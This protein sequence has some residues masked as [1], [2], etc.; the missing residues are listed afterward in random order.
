MKKLLYTFLLITTSC[1]A[2]SKFTPIATIPAEADFFTSDNQGNVYI[3]TG[4]ELTKYNKTGRLLYKY[5]DKKL[6]N[7]S[8]VDA[9]NMLRLLVFYKDFLQIVFLDNTLSVNGEA[10]S[11]DKI[12]GQQA[13]LVC[14]SHNSGIW[15]YDQQNFE[16]IRLDQNFEK[17][18]QTGNLNLLL[19]TSLQP[20]Y[21]LEY[22]NKVYLNN[23]SSGILIFDIYGTYYKTIPAKNVKKFQPITDW[24]Y[25]ISD[26]K[27]KAYNTKTTEEKQFEMPLQDFK[28]FR[29]EMGILMLQTEKSIVLYSSE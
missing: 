3:V 17:K 19:N 28:D 25:F 27:V 10:T 6:G 5:S 8:F 18:Q 14:S 9:S 13:Q 29:L 16:L 1:F 24:V 12:G 4:N 26:S 15:L 11:L 22:D 2:Q 23:P 7:I 20:D 21:L